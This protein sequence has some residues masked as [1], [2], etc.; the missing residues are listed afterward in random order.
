MSGM[1]ITI[2]RSNGTRLDQ[3]A[4][5][6][7]EQDIK[8]DQ[9]YAELYGTEDI[10]QEEKKVKELV[11]NQG[12]CGRYLQKGSIAWSCPVCGSNSSCIICQECYDNSNHKGHHEYIR[13]DI[14]GGR[15]DCGDPE[16]WSLSGSCPKHSSSVLDESK[17]SVELLPE[18]L[19]ERAS[20]TFD[21]LI[22]VLDLLCLKLEAA[23]GLTGEEYA[24]VAEVRKL[25][26]K[27]ENLSRILGHLTKVSPIFLNMISIR[28]RRSSGNLKTKHKCWLKTEA[29]TSTE[30]HICQCLTLRNYMKI[31]FSFSRSQRLIFNSQFFFSL[32]KNFNLKLHIALTYFSIYQYIIPYTIDE[33][34]LVEL[35]L[36]FIGYNQV[37]HQVLMNEPC[38]D[39][40]FNQLKRVFNDIKVLNKL[41][42]KILNGLGFQVY[43]ICRNLGKLLT[44]K[45]VLEYQRCL[46]KFIE[47]LGV[48]KEVTVGVERDEVLRRIENNLEE[49]FV[50]MLSAIDLSKTTQCTS[51]VHALDSALL[52]TKESN[53]IILHRCL[54][55]FL[56]NYLMTNYWDKV[57]N[58]SDLLDMGTR[59]NEMINALWKLPH[60]EENESIAQRWLPGVLQSV[61]NQ[62]ISR[63]EPEDQA[64][65]VT[66]LTHIA[67]FSLIVI[68]LT[69]MPPRQQLIHWLLNQMHPHLSKEDIIKVFTSSERPYSLD[70]VCLIMELS[71]H[72]I[73]IWLSNDVLY[74]KLVSYY[75]KTLRIPY[76]YLERTKIAASNYFQ[77]AIS[78]IIV[79]LYAL[80]SAPNEGIP[81]TVIQSVFP[82]HLLDLNKIE[83]AL[84]LL[85]VPYV[86]SKDHIM[87]FRLQDSALKLFDPF[88][89]NVSKN[90][91]YTLA[92]KRKIQDPNK[93]DFLFG[94]L[95]E[96]HHI[97]DKSK[98]GV[99]FVPFKLL[100]RRYFAEA[101]VIPEIIELMK[102]S[103]MTS[104]M[105]YCA[106]KLIISCTSNETANDAWKFLGENI[107]KL[108]IDDPYNSSYEDILRGYQKII[109]A[110]SSERVNSCLGEVIEQKRKEA[111]EKKARQNEAK[112]RAREEFKAKTQAFENKNHIILAQSKR[113][114]S[115][116]LMICAYCRES[117]DK[118]TVEPFGKLMYM[119]K[120]TVYGH[121]LN[122]VLK[123]VMGRYYNDKYK[124]KYVVGRSQAAVFTSCGH[125]IHLKCFSQLSKNPPENIVYKI[126][127]VS[128]KNNFLCPICQNCAN[129]LVPPADAVAID[130]S[131]LSYVAT[132]IFPRLQK[133]MHSKEDE[134]KQCA[135]FIVVCKFLNY[136]SNLISLTEVEDFA[137]KRDIMLNL[138]YYLKRTPQKRDYYDN[139]K[140][141]QGAIIHEMRFIF[142]SRYKVFKANLTY[143]FI[144]LLVASKVME[145]EE[146]KEKLEEEF[147]DKTI[148]MIKLALTQIILRVVYMQVGPIASVDSLL[149][150]FTNSKLLDLPENILNIE[151]R[152]VSFLRRI[153]CLK[154]IFSPSPDRDS[155]AEIQKAS[156]LNSKNAMEFYAKEFG[157]GDKPQILQILE[158][159]T[160]RKPAFLP[161][162]QVN[163]AW[164]SSAFESL[165]RHFSKIKDEI[166]VIPK[167][168]IVFD[169][170]PFTLI[171]LPGGFSEFKKLYQNRTCKS[172]GRA[173]E[174][175]AVC[176]LCSELICVLTPSNRGRNEGEL[177][178]HSRICPGGCGM[179]LRLINN[180]VLLIDGG[181]GCNYPSPYVNKYGESVDIQ[182][183]PSSGLLHLEKRIVEDL[184]TLYL[185]HLIPQTVRTISLKALVKFKPFCL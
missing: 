108:I 49:Q 37:I 18:L 157:L 168:I 142:K 85:T 15:C 167:G 10:K 47:C 150:V 154:T 163:L 148:L 53:V 170:Q 14:K 80:S 179:F 177:T 127:S 145:T 45:Y 125:Y 36:Q 183:N 62:I 122:Q 151:E 5:N 105:M 158:Y 117:T 93:I 35:S 88:Y 166:K 169:V 12:E 114:S 87:K 66:E 11:P 159:T 43:V 23:L 40:I 70:R 89:I 32:L 81:F 115:N 31:L 6:I 52:R 160:A 128:Y 118:Y 78:R 26:Q 107:E 25:Q 103:G 83:K 76:D 38:L 130:K 48:F 116:P 61:G 56:T 28:L 50:L 24:D 65:D 96:P 123:T 136:Q 152:L 99:S 102:G 20:N 124:F 109:N 63:S 4:R 176:L 97:T 149:E 173:K 30:T 55:I 75:R 174:D 60:I 41:K 9:I 51:V 172:C 7:I 153:F 132:S 77:Y 126:D 22:W 156:W 64:K 164:M 39:S 121:Y 16:A 44:L 146:C 120:S 46:T 171:P 2:T 29:V 175:C 42:I 133:M 33:T 21:T 73:C 91:V 54:S 86:D 104:W 181:H 165:L 95:S 59:I 182:K 155:Q 90:T 162:P 68:L 141:I 184:K 79:T 144:M 94:E 69:I 161:L 131:A 129:I 1:E 185:K 17:V 34:T 111:E 110:K 147:K 67:D 19:R 58:T 82:D 8:E 180:R 112:R 100:L 27:I 101:G 71:L 74:A 137:A 113:V 178:M 84:Q 72:T 143:I 134:T 13:R 119:Q 135:D 98:K 92:S 3:I 106:F 139:M 138:L 57:F 140:S